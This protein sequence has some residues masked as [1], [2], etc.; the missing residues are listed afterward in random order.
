MGNRRNIAC[1]EIS[2]QLLHLAAWARV[3]TWRNFTLLGGARAEEGQGG[4]EVQVVIGV[5][6]RGTQRT[7]GRQQT[8]VDHL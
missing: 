3:S 1:D 8:H 6:D 7:T 2:V 5:H 4:S